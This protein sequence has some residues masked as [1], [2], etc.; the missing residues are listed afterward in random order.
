M[1]AVDVVALYAFKEHSVPTAEDGLI[2]AEKVVGKADR[3]LPC[4]VVI[5]I[6]AV[7]FPQRPGESLRSRFQYHQ[8]GA[9]RRD[10]VIGYVV[11]CENLG[12]GQRVRT[13]GCVQPSLL[14]GAV[15]PL[16][17]DSLLVTPV[18]RVAGPQ[19]NFGAS[20]P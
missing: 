18:P 2:V 15:T 1:C 6:V 12:L 3:R 5:R 9:A 19:F 10:S 4:S 7:E 20:G 14:P 13:D 11:A 8:N 17:A 16:K